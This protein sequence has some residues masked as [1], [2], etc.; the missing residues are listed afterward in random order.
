[1]KKVEY[2]IDH[3]ILFLQTIITDKELLL[4]SQNI[5]KPQYFDP[6]LRGTVKFILS[7]V[8][9]YNEVPLPEEIYAETKIKLEKLTKIPNEFD[10]WFLENIEEF[11]RNKAVSE[12][13][14]DGPEL[15]ET[16]DYG[17]LEHKLK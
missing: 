5:I 11:C 3:Q 1:M 8:D 6:K 2:T 12:V 13:I 7:Y 4:R 16:N 10:K 9:K 14:M 15:L 17:L